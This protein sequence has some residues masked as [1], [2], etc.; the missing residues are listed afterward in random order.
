MGKKNETKIRMNNDTKRNLCSEFG[1]FWTRRPDVRE[2]TV[3][4]YAKKL[5]DKL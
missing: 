4:I 5:Y 3:F 2:F 1:M